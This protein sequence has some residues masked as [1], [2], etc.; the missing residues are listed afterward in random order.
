[1][2]KITVQIHQWLNINHSLLEF[3]QNLPN[4]CTVSRMTFLHH[5]LMLGRIKVLEKYVISLHFTIVL[6][7][8]SIA[9]FC[10]EHLNEHLRMFF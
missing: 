6:A 1:M 10:G 3:W 8:Q 4:S 5:F 7:V 2:K 9:G